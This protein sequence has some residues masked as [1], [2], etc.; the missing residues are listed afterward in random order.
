MGGSLAVVPM[1]PLYPAPFRWGDGVEGAG[2][3]KILHD[4]DVLITYI[5]VEHFK[6]EKIRDVR[7]L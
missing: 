6:D 3:G 1:C 7:A 2:K 4:E 5:H